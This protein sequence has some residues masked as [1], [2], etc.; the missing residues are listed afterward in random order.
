MN[1]ATPVDT[2]KNSIELVASLGSFLG[3]LSRMGEYQNN[4][5]LG[6]VNIQPIVKEISGQLQLVYNSLSSLQVDENNVITLKN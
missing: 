1:Q 2:L 4:G 6:A 5:F 3:D